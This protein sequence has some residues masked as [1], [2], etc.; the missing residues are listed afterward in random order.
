MKS[1]VLVSLTTIFILF[2]GFTK[3][4]KINQTTYNGETVYVYPYKTEVGYHS[5]YFKAMRGRFTGKSSTKAWFI[6]MNNGVFDKG[7]YREY[8]KY[9]RNLRG[10]SRN[11]ENKHTSKH[12]FKKAVRS[13][14]YPL[15]ERRYTLDKDIIPS[16]DRIP[17]GKYIQYFDTFALLK[18]NGKTEQIG[19]RISGIFTLKNNMLDGEAIWLGMDGDT[20]KKG[21]FV[22]GMKVGEWKLESRR[23]E[24]SLSK[25]SAK[26]YIE[27]GYPKIDT[28]TEFVTY[29]NGVMNGLYRRFENSKNPVEEG[30][31]KDNV[32]EG[33]WLERQI[34]Y[35][36]IGS[37]RKR[38][39]NNEVITFRYTPEFNGA[40]VKRPMIRFKHIPNLDYFYDENFTF[41]S[42]Y[43]PYIAFSKIY[44]LG[45]E[46]EEE[47]IE[48]EEETVSSY[49]G[50]EEE[51]MEEMYYEEEDYGY[52]GNFVRQRYD[53]ESGRYLTFPKLIDSLG[54]T[55]NFK[56]IYEKRYPNGQL[57]V[58][59]DFTDGSLVEE[60]TIYWDNGKPYDVIEFKEDS[61]Q[62]IQ[63][64]YDYTG[65]LYKQIVFD[66]TGEFIRVNFE[67]STSTFLEIDGFTAELR[68]PTDKYFF[69][70][71]LD[72]L[73]N[74]LN[75]SLVIF[76]SW[77]TG[78][79]S[80][81]YSRSYDPSDRKLNF[82]LISVKG[83]PSIDAELIFA[84]DF[85]SWTGTKDYFAGDL[86]V[87]TT[88]S[89]SFVSYYPA[90][91]FPQNHVNDFDELFEITDEHVLFNK[92]VAYSGDL[93][94]EFGKRKFNLTTGNNKIHATFPKSTK[95]PYR[96]QKDIVKFRKTGK[97]KNE[98]LLSIIDASE[99]DEVYSEGIYYNLFGNLIGQFVEFPYT[100]YGY[101][102]E[103]GRG[104]KNNY[105]YSEKVIGQFAGGKPT[106]NWKVIDQHGK[107]L[108]E[109]PFINGEIDG[110]LKVYDYK[111]PRSMDYYMD[112]EPGDTFPK[113]QTYYLSSTSDFKNGY[114]NGKTITYNWLGEII[115]EEN[116]VDGF[117]EGKAFERNKLAH[118][119]V[120]Y[121][122]G[123]LD[124]YVKTYLTLPGKDSILLFDLNFQNGL[125]QG[126]SK[127]FHINGNVAK[128]G[129]FLNGQPI[130]DYEAYDTL[131]FKYHYVKFQ[132]SFPVEEKIW[133]ENELSVR[134]LFDWRDSINFE[135]SDITSTQSLDRILYELG[136]GIEYLE[137]PY[138]GRP[139]L[140]EKKGI[141][142]H[143]TKYYP[144]DTI[145]RDGGISKG[146]KVGCWEFYSYEGELLYEVDYRDSIITIN[147]SVQFKSKGILTDFDAAGNKLS[148]SF[149]IEKFE[150]Y[151]CS[152]T[153]HY[154]I[155]QLMTIWE[156]N[157]TIGR[158]NG[159]VKNYYDNGVL[160]NEGMMKNGLPT[161]VWKFYDPYGKLNQ[162]G[163]YVLG[164]RNGRWLGGD[165]SKTKY[166]GDICLNPNL[167][168]L[169]EE[170]KYREKL[171]DIVI[172][173]YHMGKA[174]N[175]EF[176]DV[177][178]NNYEE[179]G[180]EE[181]FNEI[182][183]G[184]EER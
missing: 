71:K 13:N 111:T 37:K 152:H 18:S 184:M 90:D 3:A 117:Q 30:N 48:L 43:A 100:E 78:D 91:S 21:M 164:K 175:K 177:N 102:N 137:R 179:E 127:S 12:K 22:K 176:Y 161:G 85:E 108:Y 64:I 145:A 172:T 70:D 95:R 55:F 129:F 86:K 118:T 36:G 166:L 183:E 163:E 99:A 19:D 11:N 25:A 84:E 53:Y 59:Y 23:T 104:R 9:M 142:Y 20:L 123:S 26:Q 171:L 106:G 65:L 14:P 16:L 168:N 150:K 66:S 93:K 180:A 158:M 116:Y 34:N 8:K 47:S 89:A 29:S 136:I 114:R 141:D 147:D 62:Y 156:A 160:Q 94:I 140:I 92:G 76:R 98:L 42:K 27:L 5:D 151:D 159:Y 54:I 52:E 178:L 139:S 38:N 101:E 134:Y 7:M 49:E 109:I 41:E 107:L 154:E 10:N 103:Y 135:P 57:M 88:S 87:H 138:Y 112:M 143:M 61:S 69:Y 56:G 126:E 105:P 4:Q 75:D 81:L 181:D 24:Y 133:E 121:L 33:E 124:G 144:N 74:V 46:K 157:D 35:T 1:K 155:R 77:Y 6:A 169:E 97:A 162:V 119:N 122:Q 73:S 40:L 50:G 170:I 125:L 182:E 174:L 96:L 130:D 153:D 80:L 165:L 39:R 15:L 44:T 82:Q 58:R 31:F 128:R 79:T 51:Y 115:S 113:K 149:V 2:A 63:T 28:T 148:E 32:P 68:S 146:K 60:D 17:D 83:N 132:Y 45:G 67:T 72:T 131:G 110:V 173:N 167:P 120:N